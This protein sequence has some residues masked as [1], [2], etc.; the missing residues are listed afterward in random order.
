M[1]RAHLGD[2]LSKLS[3]HHLAR[4]DGALSVVRYSGEEV[5]MARD[6]IS[7]PSGVR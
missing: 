7:A 4:T 1:L 6:A 5:A 2:D 3:V